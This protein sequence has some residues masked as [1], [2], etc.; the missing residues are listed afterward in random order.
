MRSTT[1][2]A[3]ALAVSGFLTL[4]V[5]AGGFGAAPKI[6]Q[7]APAFT[8]RSPDGEP[9]TLGGELARGPVVLVL[10]RGWPGYQCP[11][12]TRQFGDFLAHGKDLA[13]TGARV[14]WV[15]PGPS[16]QVGQRAKEFTANRTLPGNFRIATDPDYAFTLAYGLRWD[17]PNETA[18][19]ATFVVDRG[20]I[21]R[22]AQIS[23]GHDGRA[24]AEDVLEALA[25]LPRAPRSTKPFPAPGIDA[26]QEVSR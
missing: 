19:P 22:F 12:C 24:R 13:A 2:V 17:G 5:L 16:D 6:G 1:L 18:Y 8:L 4:P 20:G 11:F 15:Y 23:I 26:F 7:K 3:L 9:V 10:L 25:A 21:V 14:I